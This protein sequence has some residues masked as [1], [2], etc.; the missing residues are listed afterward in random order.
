MREC[1]KGWANQNL[2]T[3]NTEFPEKN[4]KKLCALCG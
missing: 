1:P 4:L 2:A 3:E